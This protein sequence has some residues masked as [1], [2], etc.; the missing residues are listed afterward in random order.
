MRLGLRAHGAR[1]SARRQR[2]ERSEARH[3]PS[4]GG[5]A[6]RDEPRREPPDL[7]GGGSSRGG[8]SHRPRGRGQR[9]MTVEAKICGLSTPETVDAAVTF[10][11][12]WVGFL[13]YPRSP[14]HVSSD[15]L[16]KALGARVPPGVG[17]V[18]LFVDPSDALLKRRLS[19]GAIDLLQLHGA[20]TPERVAIIKM[21]TGKPVMKVI[22]V[23]AAGDVERGI[24]N[25]AGI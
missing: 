19:T 4:P 23:A 16:L 12:R 7:S 21:R 6:R 22:K 1:H 9:P 15:A 10:G 24:V 25:Y 17:R 18:G 3:D 14:R 20:E 13:T 5:R 11:A 2:S 8:R